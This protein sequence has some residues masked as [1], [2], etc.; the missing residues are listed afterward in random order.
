MPKACLGPDDYFSSIGHFELR[1]RFAAVTVQDLF[2]NRG[3][4]GSTWTVMNA[5]QYLPRIYCI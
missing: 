1:T 3:E 2:V 4:S 5:K